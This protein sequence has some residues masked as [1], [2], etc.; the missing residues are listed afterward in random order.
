M[1]RDEFYYGM[2]INGDSITDLRDTNKYYKQ[3]IT[4]EQFQVLQDRYYKNPI[5]ISKSK[6]K[7]VYDDIKVF[8]IDFILT[9]DNFW[10]TFNLPNLKR[11][12][13][14]IN[15]ANK[16]WI[17]LELKDVIKPNQISY[18]CANKKSS[19]YW[20]TYSQE[21]IDEQ[22]I[23]VLNDFKVEE[24]DF[25]Q[26]IEFTNTRLDDIIKTTK[27]K[28]ASVNLEI[29]RLKTK[30]DDYIRNNMSIKKDV[31]ENK[32]YEDT[33][34]DYDR[35]IKILRKQIE[36]MDDTERNEIVELEVFIDVLNNAKE[37]Y[38]KASYVQKRKIAK[39]LFLNIKINTKKELAVQ[40]KPE[41]QTLFNPIWWS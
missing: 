16:K 4:E 20:I 33:K 5:V 28:Q 27:E 22:I 7:D 6:T 19:Y 30:K 29:S 39:I 37:Y 18:R 14:K 32:I 26:Y 40:I 38:K 35:K 17:I 41:L 24:K 23:K 21:D 10:L 1:F 34:S 15:E 11:Y 8:D 36:E 25:K 2:F 3:V 13:A 9:D 12:E 31:D